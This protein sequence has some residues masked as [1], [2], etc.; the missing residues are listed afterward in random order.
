MFGLVFV[1]SF[2]VLMTCL[3]VVGFYNCVYSCY[4]VLMF[5]LLVANWPFCINRFDKT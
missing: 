4:T 1:F 3:V 5:A 2:F